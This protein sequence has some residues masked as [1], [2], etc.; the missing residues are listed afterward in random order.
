[1]IHVLAG[2][3]TTPRTHLYLALMMLAALGCGDDDKHKNG[4]P[5]ASP[6]ATRTVAATTS[7]TATVTATATYSPSATATMADTATATGTATHTDTTTSTPTSTPT[8][9]ETE[10]PTATITPTASPTATASP[11]AS[12][13]E[14]ESTPTPT[15]T[16]TPSPSATETPTVSPLAPPT[17]LQVIIFANQLR[18]SWSN[19]DTGTEVRLLRRAGMVPQG[20]D[21]PQATVVYSGSFESAEEDRGTLLGAVDGSVYGYA[22]YGCD[23]G[24]CEAVGSTTLVD[25]D[26]V[27]ELRAGGFV[28]HWRHASADVCSDRLNLGVAATTTSPGWWRSCTGAPND[29]ADATARQL[30]STGEAESAFL[31]QVLRENEIPFGRVASSEYCRNFRTAEGMN[32]GPEIEL[33][34]DISY[35]VYDESERCQH[36]RDLVAEVPSPG[37]NTAIIGHAGFPGPCSPF[38]EL[39]WAEV[40]IFRPDGNGTARLT[41]RIRVNEWQSLAGVRTPTPVITPVPVPANPSALIDGEVVRLAWT[42]PEPGLGFSD[43]RIQRRLNTPPIG[44]DDPDATVIYAGDATSATDPLTGL[45]PSTAADTRVYHYAIHACQPGGE[46]AEVAAR[47][48]VTPTL[49]QALRAGGYVIHWRHA[50][51][52]VCADQITLGSAATTTSPGWWRSCDSNCETATARQLNAT[53]IAQSAAIGDAVRGQGIPIGR[54]L[55]SEYCRAVMTA[56]GFAFT[57]PIEERPDITYLVY[58]EVGRCDAAYALLAQ[59]PEAGTNTAVVGHGYLAG[60]CPVLDV[61]GMGEAAIFKPQPDGSTLFIT[62][63]GDTTW[64]LLSE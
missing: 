42:A 47:V 40:A 27:R 50:P 29:C 31:G 7:H 2:A 4:S 49:L 53:G 17:D 51:A 25:V 22:V 9:T 20:P 58:D 30:N 26:L 41:A 60:N 45:L 32:L 63:V 62:R 44:P 10:V 8:P 56:E 6:T 33:R 15:E 43:V 24:G 54:T 61:I 11:S 52:T 57:P 18:L 3:M 37:T 23:D 39:A 48:S 12:A 13:T 55:S 46:C 21:D 28:F 64:S 5:I 35:F 16:A 36:T 1:V 34:S 19:P 59:M 14:A 38:G